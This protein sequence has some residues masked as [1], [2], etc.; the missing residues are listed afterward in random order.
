MGAHGLSKTMEREKPTKLDEFWDRLA[1]AIL[2]Y[3]DK[4]R[5]KL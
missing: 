3:D 1:A 5:R 4:R 2:K